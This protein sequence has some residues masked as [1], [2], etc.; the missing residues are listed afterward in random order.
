MVIYTEVYTKKQIIAYQAR[1]PIRTKSFLCILTV[2]KLGQEQNINEAWGIEAHHHPSSLHCYCPN[3]R[4]TRLCSFFPSY[5][6]LATGK[7]HSKIQ[8]ETSFEIP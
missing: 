2:R 8:G 6:M 3:L 5:G 7:G 4:V 1:V